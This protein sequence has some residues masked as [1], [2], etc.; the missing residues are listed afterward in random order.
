MPFTFDS[1]MRNNFFTE[2]ISLSNLFR[3]GFL[4]QWSKCLFH[5]SHPW[6]TISVNDLASKYVFYFEKKRWF[7]AESLEFS[8]SN[9]DLPA[10]LLCCIY[11]P[12]KS[13]G[14]TNCFSQPGSL[15][16]FNLLCH[17]LDKHQNMEQDRTPNAL[18]VASFSVV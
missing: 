7:C 14:T 12:T 5:P 2:I 8:L 15:T 6:C 13:D 17:L 18:C 3:F 11:L 4:A 10:F 9:L 1:Q 16:A